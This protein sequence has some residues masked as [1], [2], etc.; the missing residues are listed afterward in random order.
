MI[1]GTDR[2]VSESRKREIKRLGEGARCKVVGDDNI[3]A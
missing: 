1:V 3:A 2:I